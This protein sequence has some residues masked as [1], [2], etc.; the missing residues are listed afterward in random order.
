MSPAPV[1]RAPPIETAGRAL[2]LLCDGL[3]RAVLAELA[4]HGPLTRPVLGARLHAGS[5]RVFE[6]LRTLQDAG[7]TRASRS[8][9]P[10]RHSITGSGRAL[11]AIAP[12]VE[13]W[14]GAHPGGALEPSVGWRAFED[15]GA[16]WRDGV[17]EWVVRLAPSGA[18]VAR[19]LPAFE[20]RRLAALL[21]A[22]VEAGT[23]VTRRGRDG[24]RHYRLSRWT[25]CAVG[26]LAA[27]A[28]WEESFRPAGGA[29]IEVEDALVAILATLPLVRLGPQA[30][31]LHTL[32]AEA[33]GAP[34][35]A[36]RTAM[37]WVRLRGG[38]P[39]AIGEGA[40]P[41]PA[42]GWVSGG[43]E[44]WLAAVLD[45]SGRTLRSGGREEV[46]ARDSAA[47][48]AELHRVL[49]DPGS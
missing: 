17:I 24:R 34:A 32:S 42:D 14:S 5:T 8:G 47:L 30:D 40:P 9:R 33:D 23:L 44:D 22:M 31:G 13:A 4:T 6:C 16:A 37:A 25:A 48:V 3:R 15:V 49:G 41:R 11:L 39:V 46:G 2:A 43:F 45:G 12:A 38:R 21:A 19:G 7:L 20:G 26:P 27:L 29:R 10:A 35:G 18:E 1:L 28:R 36:R